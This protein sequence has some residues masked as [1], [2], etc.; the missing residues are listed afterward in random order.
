VTLVN[1]LRRGQTVNL[2]VDGPVKQIVN[3]FDNTEVTLP[4]A[5]GSL[6]PVLLSIEWTTR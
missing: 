1:F 5:L 3:L 2:A 6:D 4:L